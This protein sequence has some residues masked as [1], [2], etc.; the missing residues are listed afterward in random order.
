VTDLGNKVV[1]YV[2]ALKSRY[3]DRDARHKDVAAIRDGDYDSV[4]PGI[5][6][7][8]FPRA[9]VANLID[10]AARDIAELMAP[11]P[12]VSCASVSMTSDT[13]KRFA[14]KRGRIANG[15]VQ[16]S[17]LA[18]T[19]YEGTD[20]HNTFGFMAYIV[21][22]NFK[23]MSPTIRIGCVPSAY[24]TLDYFG[25]CK[26]YAEVT[27]QPADVL[28]LQFPE[29]AGTIE[30]VAGRDV[31]GSTQKK[32]LEV[33]CYFDKDVYAMVLVESKTVLTQAKNPISR[34]PVSVVQRPTVTSSTHGQFD[35]VIW[36]QI[37]RAMVQAYMLQAVEDS[38]NAPLVVPTGTNQIEMGPKTVLET[39]NPQGVG[40]L[41]LNIPQGVFPAEQVL[42]QEQLTGSRYTGARTGNVNASIITGQGVD[43][44][45]A[46]FDTQIQTFQRLDKLA[47][48]DALSMALEMDEAVW[49]DMP[50]SIEIDDAGSP[51]QVKYTPSKD[52]DGDYAVTVSYG[53]IA[54]LDP[55]R[56]LVYI[57]QAVQAQLISLDTARRSMAG[58]VDINPTA[59]QENIDVEAIRNALTGAIAALPQAIPMLATQGQDVRVI[60][61]QIAEILRLRQ[62]G[63][64]IDQAVAEV[65][66]PKQPA[67]QQQA[68]PAAPGAP[69][70]PPTPQTPGQDVLASLAGLTASGG[71][72]LNSTVRMTG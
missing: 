10:T 72:N 63:K 53:A 54:G 4:A 42:Q 44:L 65:F 20:R 24:Y 49:G 51:V 17:R 12:G 16:R 15:Y 66:A 18:T 34:C 3:A 48:A 32:D 6:P 69:G 55:N 50:K 28:I 35:D 56:G 5:F 29:H 19:R 14:E 61:M 23:E 7:P 2:T 39:D 47:L 60:A 43:A 40:R 27:R 36:V 1:D 62:K 11:M 26:M 21:E 71:A 8:E 68:A 46:G 64:T 52:I 57:L 9:M 33:V 58:I 22:P 37:V 70:A 38:V 31:Y 67:D 41:Q 25:R 59:E 13:A 45:N 30:R